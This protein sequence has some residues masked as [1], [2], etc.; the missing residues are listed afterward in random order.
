MRKVAKA[1]VCLAPTKLAVKGLANMAVRAAVNPTGA[2]PRARL[3]ASETLQ[4][5][6]K[7]FL[8]RSVVILASIAVVTASGKLIVVTHATLVD[9]RL[10]PALL[11]GR[12]AGQDGVQAV[13]VGIYGNKTRTRFVD[14]LGNSPVVGAILLLFVVQNVGVEGVDFTS[15][16]VSIG[17]RFLQDLP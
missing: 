3:R 8:Q 12:D 6:L 5:R 14:G 4:R 13:V 15:E 11:L 9:T 2:T 16:D 7:V 17:C 10:Q 1:T